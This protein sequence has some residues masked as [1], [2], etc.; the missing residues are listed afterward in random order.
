M[1]SPLNIRQMDSN[2]KEIMESD[3]KKL[4]MSQREYI[5]YLILAEHER[6]KDDKYL[7]EQIKTKNNIR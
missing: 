5:E 7:L 4:G 2:I 3:R 1:F 6:L